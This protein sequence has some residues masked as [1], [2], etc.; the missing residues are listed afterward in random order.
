[1]M[2]AQASVQTSVI[3]CCTC[4][5][6]HTHTC[7]IP[8]RWSQFP[9]SVFN[10]RWLPCSSD[11]QCL[12]GSPL[13]CPS[14]HIWMPTTHFLLFILTHIIGC[15]LPVLA[16]S[17]VGHIL[18][19]TPT[20]LS[21]LTI[22]KCNNYGNCKMPHFFTAASVQSTKLLFQVVC[23]Y[24]LATSM[25]SVVLIPQEKPS[26]FCV[27]PRTLALKEVSR[28]CQ[29]HNCLVILFI[30]AIATTCFGRAWPSS[31][32]NVDV[33][34]KWEKH[35]CMSGWFAAVVWVGEVRCWWGSS[36]SLA[37]LQ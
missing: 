12:P 25:L 15:H 21:I 36:K 1:M 8:A 28:V 32:H 6:V 10:V 22:V 34:H 23:V 17:L 16:S 30:A 18:L 19:M 27:V 20:G 3:H 4:A 31:G 26:Q 7:R 14:F 11:L 13:S 33:V 24:K 37:N 9:S 2:S 35:D 5:C 29:K